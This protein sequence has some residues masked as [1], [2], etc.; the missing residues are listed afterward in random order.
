MFLENC[1][2]IRFSSFVSSHLNKNTTYDD[3]RKWSA[4]PALL[5]LMEAEAEEESNP[6][7]RAVTLNRDK[8]MG[9]GFVAGSE[10]P[11]IVRYVCKSR[12]FNYRVQCV[13]GS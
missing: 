3:P 4:D 13:F 2:T 12:L 8:E 9:F 10:K 5:A 11:V 7:P 1:P 6:E